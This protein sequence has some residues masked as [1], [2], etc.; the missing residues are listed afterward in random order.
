MG[1][2]EKNFVDY[3]GPIYEKKPEG[4]S[5]SCGDV[6]M[7]KQISEYVQSTVRKKGYRY[8]KGDSRCPQNE[9]QSETVDSGASDVEIKEKLFDGILNL[10]QPYGEDVVSLFK[11]DMVIVTNENGTISGRIRCVLCDTQFGIDVKKK[12]RRQEF[13]SQFWN[14]QSWCLSNY[15]NHH[16]QK[17]HPIHT[18]ENQTTK[19]KHLHEVKSEMV[20]SQLTPANERKIN[21]IDKNS[22]GN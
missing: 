21:C 13:Y 1:G 4:F 9:G 20:A 22:T 5:F 19:K 2:G 15:S 17:V 8:F 7:L 16:L 10:L 12:R 11:K 14:G 6:K 18:D 3:F